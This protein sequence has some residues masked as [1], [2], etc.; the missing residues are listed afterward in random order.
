MKRL[1]LATALSMLTAGSAMA[2]TV[3]LVRH[4]TASAC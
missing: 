1:L 3:V 4:G 2:Q